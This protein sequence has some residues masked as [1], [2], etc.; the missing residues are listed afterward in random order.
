M[1]DNY[2]NN[3]SDN[4]RDLNA[5]K[6]RLLIQQDKCIAILSIGA[7]KRHLITDRG[8]LA[9]LYH[10]NMLSLA[11]VDALCFDPE[12]NDLRSLH[13]KSTYF[14]NV[15]LSEMKQEITVCTCIKLVHSKILIVFLSKY[16]I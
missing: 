6:K 13:A 11:A 2:L 5:V 8:K 12:S 10:C 7:Y 3:V 15:I 1:F 16:E 9:S 4:F 14:M